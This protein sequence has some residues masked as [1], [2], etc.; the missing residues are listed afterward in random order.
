MQRDQI[1]EL[2]SAFGA[3][4]VRRMFG[5]AGIYRDGLMFGLVHDGTL[6]LK[7]DEV[8]RADFERHQQ[9]PFSYDTKAGRRVL[10][11]YWRVPD[12]LYD[13]PE[14]LARW[15]AQAC[16]AARRAQSRGKGRR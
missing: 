1:I 10:T 16:A 7:A 15:S 3:V 11:S 9:L 12:Q 2:F 5:G 6:Y 4:D 13:D 14:E 8:T